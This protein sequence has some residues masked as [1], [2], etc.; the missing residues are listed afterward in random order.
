MSF[1]LA[2]CYLLVSHCSLCCTVLEAHVCLHISRLKLMVK[3]RAKC[4]LRLENALAVLAIHGK[5][6][7]H[8]L[9]RKA[10]SCSVRNTNERFEVDAIDHFTEVLKALNEKID[11]QITMIETRQHPGLVE[12][13]DS[14]NDV[15][16]SDSFLECQEILVH[17]E[18]KKTKYEAATFVAA[19]R[20]LESME[21][22]EIP[23]TAK[24][25]VT[26]IAKSVFVKAPVLAS[27]LA[28]NTAST[29][30]GAGRAIKK[31][32][33]KKSNKR[34]K[35]A[36]SSVSAT[37]DLISSV[38]LSEDDG[39]ADDAG[40]VT[41][42]SLVATQCALQMLQHSEPLVLD[43]V[44]APDEP[45]HILWGNVGKDKEVLRT[46]RLLSCAVT[47]LICLSWTFV[48]TF[49]VNV[50]HVGD[51]FKGRED[52]APAWLE[53]MLALLSPL[54]LL[55]FNS[56]LLPVILK[57]VSRL[58]CPASGSL[59]EASAFWKMATFTIVQT[60]L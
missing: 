18:N 7:R 54:L 32:A 27:A 22:D 45:R 10:A 47:V 50:Q 33:I 25:S 53:Q 23:T 3:K 49:I 19:D 52:A 8:L 35:Q 58:E 17:D 39:T 21:A 6:P 14:K 59:L 20:S 1:R 26:S 28:S 13:S 36:L 11:E 16:L 57:A 44:A 38:I 9:M 30:S 41:F 48:V 29:L 56:G 24:T 43:A 5:R 60:F 40:F 51:W 34:L 42:T 4:I 2:T 37:V 12:S 15:P 31:K 55:I 46:G